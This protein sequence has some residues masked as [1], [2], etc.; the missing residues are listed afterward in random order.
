[1]LEIKSMGVLTKLLYC[2][3]LN[4][5]IPFFTEQLNIPIIFT[6][7]S[8]WRNVIGIHGVSLSCAHTENEGSVNSNSKGEL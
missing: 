4:L 3:Y 1:M 5:P 6:V 7:S 8:S 2:G